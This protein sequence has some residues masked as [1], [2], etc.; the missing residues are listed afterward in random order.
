M[1]DFLKFALHH[2]VAAEINHLEEKQNASGCD[3]SGSNNSSGSST[4]LALALERAFLITDIH[5]KHVGI[6]S[7]GATVAM[8]LIKVR[9]ISVGATL[10]A[11]SSLFISLT[12]PYFR[13]FAWQKLHDRVE[14]VAANAGDARIVLCTNSSHPTNI[15]AQ[16]HGSPSA[17]A[18]PSSWWGHPVAIRLTT[19]HNCANASECDRIEKSGGFVFRNRVVGVLAIT[20]SLGDQVLKPY[21]LAHPFICHAAALLPLSSSNSDDNRATDSN[22]DSNKENQSHRETEPQ[23]EDE[24]QKLPAQESAEPP[25]ARSG[26]GS[27][28]RGDFVIVACDGLWD[29]MDDQT[30][31]NVVLMHLQSGVPPHDV[32]QRLVDE[33][34]RRGTTDNVS[35]MVVFL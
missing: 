11:S 10:T 15:F 16:P 5:A 17:A 34:L 35:A 14:I 19:D 6:S 2:H 21:V 1:V 26:G 32:A 9:F 30:A 12:P 31:V 13:P 33:A 22:A 18:P 25:T 7:S 28:T 23:P 24:M 3:N 8:C 29:V 20:R 4:D 27:I